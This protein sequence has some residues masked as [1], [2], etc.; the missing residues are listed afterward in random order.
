[1][2]EVDFA[3]AM[4]DLQTEYA[5]ARDGLATLQNGLSDTTASVRA[6]SRQVSATVD[7][8]GR[9]TE[10][11]FHGQSYRTMAPAELAKLVVETVN[12]AHEDAQR[13]LWKSAAA[14][15]PAN[16][17]VDEVVDGDVNW[18]NTLSDKLA[19]PK[20]VQDMLD[21]PVPGAAAHRNR[22]DED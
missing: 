13:D 20:L 17:T 3:A 5:K 21:R 16:V 14:F 4:K 8:R 6:K 2:R 7:A 10:L 1:M 19:L 12:R 22:P 9:L 15:L 11:K 18:A